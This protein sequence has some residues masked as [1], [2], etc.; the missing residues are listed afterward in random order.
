MTVLKYSIGIRLSDACKRTCILINSLDILGKLRATCRF[1]KLTLPLL[2]K[3]MEE[4]FYT[5]GT[6][7]PRPQRR[8]DAKYIGPHSIGIR[9]LTFSR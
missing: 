3:S 9:K 4:A 8:E 7:C 2:C 1:L 5:E 6:E